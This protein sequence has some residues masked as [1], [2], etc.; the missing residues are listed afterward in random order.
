MPSALVSGLEAERI[1]LFLDVDGTLLDLAP[2]PTAVVVPGSLI[3]S[4]ARAEKA[5]E[6]ALALVSGRSIDDL[7]RLFAPLSLRASGV[8]GAEIRFTPADI[9]RPDNAA[10][11]LPRKLWMALTELLFDFPGTFAEN[12]RFSFAVHYRT[13]PILKGRLREELE[14]FVACHANLNLSLIHG[15]S[16]FEI[17]AQGFDKGSAIEKFIKRSPF[18]G[19]MPIFIGDDSSDEAGFAAVVRHGGQ[20]FSVGHESPG[21]S[22]VFPGPESVRHWLAEFGWP[23]PPA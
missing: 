4:L 10:T 3:S 12:K 15:H 11:S 8:H 22:G 17:K 6:G 1:A 18:L 21:V 23:R 16:V 9:D 19:R 2:R 5:L 7:D 14:H 13:V 20:A